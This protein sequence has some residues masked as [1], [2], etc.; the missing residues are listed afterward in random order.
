MLQSLLVGV[1]HRKVR[2][3]DEHVDLV[4]VEPQLIASAMPTNHL[5][6]SLYHTQTATLDAFLSKR[7]SQ[8][9]HIWCLQEDH[10]LGYDTANFAGREDSSLVTRAPIRDHNPPSFAALV[11]LVR[12]IRAYLEQSP[13][14]VALVHCKCGKGR[15]GTVLSTYLMLYKG[16]TTVQATELFGKKRMRFQFIAGVS[17]PSQLRYLHYVEFWNGA[18]QPDAFLQPRTIKIKRILVHGPRTSECTLDVSPLTAAEALMETNTGWDVHQRSE[19]LVA[20]PAGPALLPNDIQITYT[21]YRMLRAMPVP[22][23]RVR[24][25]FNA[26]FEAA[27]AHRTALTLQEDGARTDSSVS[28]DGSESSAGYRYQDVYGLSREVSCTFAWEDTDGIFGTSLRGERAFESLEV[29]FAVL[30]KRFQ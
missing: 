9:W 16:L 10:E 8:E 22:T 1:A 13:K 21:A 19:S 20:R 12:D 7:H 26:L 2:T 25:S 14:H 6:Q 28:T 23:A 27:K 17:I 24:V 5:V 15:T 18:D 3:V 11:A 29:V 4:Y 30:D